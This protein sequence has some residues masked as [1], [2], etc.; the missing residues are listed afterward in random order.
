VIA[1]SEFNE[2]ISKILDIKLL[3]FNTEISKGA[4]V[5]SKVGIPSVVPSS[6]VASC[7]NAIFGTRRSVGNSAFNSA[8][9]DGRQLHYPKAVTGDPANRGRRAPLARQLEDFPGTGF[10]VD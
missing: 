8:L 4:I 1:T 2:F 6:Y 10:N 5:Y 3:P 7:C 9:S